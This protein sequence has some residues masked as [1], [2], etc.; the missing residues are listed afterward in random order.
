MISWDRVSEL[1]DE[2][3]P[4]DFSEVA[5]MFLEE[6]DEVIARLKAAPNPGT[7]EE[8]MHF[9]KGSALNLGFS[10]FSDLCQIREKAASQG[11]AETINMHEV[12]VSYDASKIAFSAGCNA[13]KAA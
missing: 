11:Q 8:D 6:V 7:Y 1:R 13:M 4:E 2:I 9:L 12:F 5:E 3:G 10:Q